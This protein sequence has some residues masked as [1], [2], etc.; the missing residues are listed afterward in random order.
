M[1]DERASIIIHSEGKG[2]CPVRWSQVSS[3]TKPPPPPPVDPPYFVIRP[4]LC[5]WLLSHPPDPGSLQPGLSPTGKN[6]ALPEI[7]KPGWPIL[8]RFFSSI[9]S[10]MTLRNIFAGREAPRARPGRSN[11]LSGERFHPSFPSVTPETPISPW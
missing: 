5:P 6:G 1:V 7:W 11:F 4:R 2:S 3:R 10:R 9:Q 8:P